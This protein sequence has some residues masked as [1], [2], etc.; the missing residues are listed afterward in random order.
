MLFIIFIVYIDKKWYSYILNGFLI[1]MFISEVVSY[2]IFFNLIDIEYW[3]HIGV[4]YSK[5][6]A[7]DPSPFTNH[8]K[9][10]VFLVIAM[11]ISVYNL[12]Y[13][14][15][16]NRLFKYI[17]ILFL[18]TAFMN[19]FINGGRTG[20]LILIV[21]TILILFEISKT[22]KQFFICLAEF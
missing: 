14:K 17:S 15:T 13:E 5:T 16:Q 10:S 9:Y 3:K 8:I 12:L 18:F 1:A 19:I 4:L 2:S 11:I 21:S 22:K 7:C 20:Q 6:N